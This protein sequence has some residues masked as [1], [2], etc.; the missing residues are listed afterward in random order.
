[1]RQRNQKSV[2]LLA[3]AIASIAMCSASSAQTWTGGGT[4]DLWGSAANWG[5]T[6]PL[7]GATTD[8]IFAGSTRL[9]PNNNYTAF[10]DFRNVL[11]ASGAGAFTLNG[12]SIDLLGKIENNSA[13][14]QTI[15]F[16]GIGVNTSFVE[17]NPAAAD[18]DFNTANL[19]LN[20]NQL[21]VWGNA[22]KVLT[23]GTGSIISGT[24]GSVAINQN[25]VVRYQSA[26]TY[27][28]DTF[29]NAGRLDMLSGSSIAN[30]QI[31]LGDTTGTVAGEFRLD[32][33]GGGYTFD[34][35]IT[36]RSG[37]SGTK[38]ISSTNTTGTN[39]LSGAV[40]LNA[41][42][43]FDVANGGTLSASSALS[44]TGALTKASAGT[45]ALSAVNTYSGA[46]TISAGTLQISGTGSLNSGAYAGSINNDGTFLYSSSASQTLSGAMT[47]SGGVTKG[48]SSTS[49]LILTNNALSTYSGP[50]LVTAG[51]L[52]AD[53]A[54]L[55]P[56]GGLSPNSA[57]TVTGNSSGGGQLNIGF[58]VNSTPNSITI[59]GVGFTEA[60]PTV[61]TGALRIQGGNNLTGTITLA[62]DSRIGML[63][64]ASP[65]ATL[66][67]QITGLYALEFYAAYSANGGGGTF[68]LNSTSG[69]NNY[70][71]NTSISTV[72]S[73]APR[74]GLSTTLK[75]IKS[76][77]IP[78]GTGRGN[79]VFNG[80]DANHKTILELN[81]LS[82][83][84]NGLSNA[85]AVGAEIK[86]TSTGASTLTVGNANTSSSFSGLIT[87]GGAG[88]TLAVTKTG[89]G[90]L[91][92][93]ASNAYMGTTTISAGV[94]EAATL[95]NGGSVSGIGQSSNAAANLVFGAP[96]ATLRYTGS[97]NVTVD[98][99]FTLSSG[100]GGGAT[101]ES[102]GSGTLS[103]DN[104]VAINYG[105][106][107]QTRV[108]TLGGTNVG[109]NTFGKVIADNTSSTSLTK[110]GAG[111]WVLNQVNTFSGTTTIN[112]GTLRVSSGSA[113]PDA[114]VVT[115]GTTSAAT[116]QVS[117]SETIAAL[118]GGNSSFGSVTID[119]AQTLTLTGGGGNT[120]A[121]TIGGAGAL[122]LSS[123]NQ[124]LN[125]A[126]SHSGGV[127][128][129]GTG[130][131]TL[132]SVSSTYTGVT[133]IGGTNGRS[134][135][136]TA[137]NALGATGIG[138]ETT[139][140]TSG[141]LG[142]SGG[143]TYSAT[144]KVVGSGAGR[145][146]SGQGA[147]TSANRGFIQ[148][149]SGSNTFAGN[150]ELSADGQSRI[151][152]QDGA[153]LTLTGT[154]TQASGVT[155]GSVLFRAGNTG[156]DFITLSNAGNSFGGDSRV[157]SGAG[158]GNWAGVR[159][160]VS[161]A[162][163][164]NLTIAAS[165]INSGGTALDLNGKDQTLN[166]L[167]SGDFGGQMTIV[168]MDTV[169]P[170]TLTL[171]PSV[172]KS[173]TTTLIGGGGGLGVINVV[174]SGN[175]TQTLAGANTYTGTTTISAGTLQIGSNGT[176]GTLGTGNVTN[177]AALVFN[178]SDNI[179]VG[180]IISGTGTVTKSGGGTLT[181]LGTQT[182]AGATTVSAGSLLVSG[183]LAT[184]S[185]AVSVSSGAT[186][187]GSG[188]IDRPVTLAGSA[189]LA[190]GTSA[191]T[192]TI[193]NT[194][195]LNDASVLSYE[196]LASDTTAG[197][198]VND[199]TTVSGS[200]VLD[201]IL[202][203]TSLGGNNATDFAGATIGS[204]WYLFSYT[205]TLTDNVLTLGSLPTLGT[206]RSWG[207]S[208]AS[209]SVNLEII[210][211]PAMVAGAALIAVSALRRRRSIL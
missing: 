170:S 65:V 164:T 180:N 76:E 153:S 74:T 60:D 141:Q 124:T 59:S 119:S 48:T 16:A 14:K 90:T 64:S 187:G 148:S 40:T 42:A 82:E 7:P 21:R 18:I 144:E 143:I 139:V 196:L 133:A 100:A 13:N 30:S 177:N 126:L 58:N 41:P 106:A 94:L 142:F 1:M 169:N 135:L 91:T 120:Y 159:L 6:A 179:S 66:A 54:G 69:S 165:A 137:N 209:G 174:K 57:V 167:V 149:V 140:G 12:N 51:R 84:V 193:G 204:K 39:T 68:Q 202:N 122:T 151:G 53:R 168:N 190:P 192:L 72:D 20:G 4:D 8:L 211:E 93:S 96:S 15:N 2:T 56:Y 5:G 79:L 24:G 199:L 102:S 83:T 147:F 111:M 11:F 175:F 62:G 130:I 123:G 145:S 131:L 70:T 156:G 78:D 88:K 95:A 115:L 136:V 182:Y 25:S 37:S 150:I 114:G 104:T 163:P 129:T 210:P 162:L 47:G 112:G 28:G 46:T 184:S 194:L 117:S 132:G 52:T 146:D 3:A 110:A 55:G 118:S 86:N 155:T 9:T 17:V 138:N 44:G 195:T 49:T 191:G 176:S 103:F 171:N 186:I 38:T 188:T 81:A 134:L 26:H 34:R 22:G 31:Q 85:S 101:I 208:F 205:G 67:G 200:L 203:V 80:A 183:V 152:T 71:G 99:G 23:F 181:L 197:G 154:I 98:R 113:L 29:V 128:V 158:A 27:S 33:A 121:G 77:Q 206:G 105:T 108:L 89:A 127:N 92:L 109:S 10:D 166:G 73:A 32:V 189:T 87:D 63:S 75:L 116:L 160:G 107:S 207:I 161:N 173:S 45:L 19:F 201:G 125:G 172:D 185:S 35:A 198:G 157:F 43:T 36:V 61:K 50:T 178:R 97:A